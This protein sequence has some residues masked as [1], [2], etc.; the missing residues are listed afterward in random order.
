MILV[1][2]PKSMLIESTPGSIYEVWLVCKGDIPSERRIFEFL[3]PKLYEKFKVELL[4]CRIDGNTAKLTITGSPFVW[5]IL[6]TWLPTILASIGLIV[7]LIAVYLVVKSI[8]EWLAA[9]LIIGSVMLGIGGG[10][11]YGARRK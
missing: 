6:L 10:M 8:P 1:R 7:L 3:K 5:S 4:D 2:I 9:L 11:L